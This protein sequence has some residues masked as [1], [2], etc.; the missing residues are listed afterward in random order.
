MAGNLGMDIQQWAQNP[1]KNTPTVNGMIAACAGPP[2]PKITLV[3]NK[4][5]IALSSSDSRVTGTL[6]LRLDPACCPM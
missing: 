5:E 4:N 6:E 1:L 2:Q 3:R